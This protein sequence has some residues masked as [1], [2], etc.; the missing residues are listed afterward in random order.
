M[1]I[2]LG[3]RDTLRLEA[4]MALYG[5]DIDDT[6]TVLEAGLSWIVKPKK[7]E[8]VGSE[9]LAREAA[10]GSKRALVGFEMRGRGIARHGYP[11][12]VGDREVGRVTSGTHAPF[13]KKSI[14]LAYVP[15]EHAEV[16][17]ELGRGI[18]LNIPLIA[19]AMDTV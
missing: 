9:A 2:G 13:L 12:R 19:A 11:V 5:N 14:G 8:F 3:A 4:K 7:G 18:R 17:T 1:P 6:T 15:A 16:G 10:S